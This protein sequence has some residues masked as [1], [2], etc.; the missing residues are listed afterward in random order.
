LDLAVELARREAETQVPLRMA[1]DAMTAAAE[2]MRISFMQFLSSADC[3]KERI[4]LAWNV[5]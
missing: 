1:Q 4:T 3:A 2:W 5:Q